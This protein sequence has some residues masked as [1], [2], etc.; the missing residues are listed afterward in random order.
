MTVKELRPILEV[1]DENIEVEFSIV[2][3]SRQDSPKM[4]NRDVYRHRESFSSRSSKDGNRDVYRTC[5]SFTFG[6]AKYIVDPQGLNVECWPIYNSVGLIGYLRKTNIISI[7]DK[8]QARTKDFKYWKRV[9]RHEDQL[10]QAIVDFVC[11]EYDSYRKEFQTLF[12]LEDDWYFASDDYPEFDDEEEE[13]DYWNTYHDKGI[14]PLVY[15]V[16]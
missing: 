14:V 15:F 10:L 1:L 8:D 6:H 12:T 5:G 7:C 3:H 9:S 13:E 2:N 16:K 11:V 4:E